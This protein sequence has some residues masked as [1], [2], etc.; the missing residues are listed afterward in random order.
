MKV[1]KQV[2]VY[3]KSNDNEGYRMKTI[4]YWFWNSKSL[5]IGRKVAEIVKEFPINH[6]I[7]N[8]QVF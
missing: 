4:R 7:T 5:T 8:I 6:T 1:K 2:I 3:Y